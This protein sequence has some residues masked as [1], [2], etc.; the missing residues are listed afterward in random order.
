M[1][2]YFG[3]ASEQFTL[4]KSDEEVIPYCVSKVGALISEEEAK[5]FN[6]IK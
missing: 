1:K 2:H 3:T 6:D 4:T 5:K